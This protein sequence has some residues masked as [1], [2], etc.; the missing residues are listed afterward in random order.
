[1]TGLGTPAQRVAVLIT[2]ALFAPALPYISYRKRDCLLLLVPL[3]GFAYAWQLGWRLAL[4]PYRD[5][6]P[7]EDEMTAARS[8]QYGKLWTHTP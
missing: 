6:R 3:W 7:R 8:T 4:L 1:M 2:L 5:W